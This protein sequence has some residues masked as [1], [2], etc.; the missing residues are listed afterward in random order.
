LEHEIK[1]GTSQDSANLVKKG[2]LVN[3]HWEETW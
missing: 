1:G 2:L 3:Q